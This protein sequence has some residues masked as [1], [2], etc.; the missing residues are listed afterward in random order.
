MKDNLNLAHVEDP[1]S[2]SDAPPGRPRVLVIED[3]ADMRDFLKRILER[4]GYDFFGAGDGAQGIDL[5]LSERPDLI[6]MDLSLPTLD[7]YEATRVLRA[8]AVFSTVPILAV[9]A[10]ARSVDQA[11]ALEV[12]CDGYISKPYG[13]HELFALLNKH[14]PVT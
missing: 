13:I 12:G 4:R 6:L 14:L 11:R 7:G 10:H 9:T 5:A 2:D 1:V 3:N 8:Q